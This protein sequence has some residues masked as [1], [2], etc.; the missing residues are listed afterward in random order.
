MKQAIIF[1]MDGT[2]FQTHRILGPALEVAFT[3]LR[4]A[5]KWHDATPL[6][7]YETIMGVPL[8][9]VWATL[10]P[11]HPETD[12]KQMDDWFQQALIER[13]QTGQGALYPDAVTILETLHAS[14]H[15]L[16]VA[17][18]GLSAYLAAIVEQFALDRYL[19]GVYSIEDV[20]SLNKAELVRMIRTKHGLREGYVVGDRQSDFTAAKENGW[21]AIGCRFDFAQE[22][23]LAT[24]EHVVDDLL[25]ITKIV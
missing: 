16:Y 22:A 1:D 4:Q 10:L 6:D 19:T 21:P 24:A 14:G 13:I 17:S 11:A 15:E 18:N 5:G 2:L 3:K 25:T 7:T 23:E 20:D 12:R 8:P 9:Q